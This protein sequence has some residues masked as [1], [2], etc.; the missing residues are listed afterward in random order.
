MLPL[1]TSTWDNKEV[2]SINEVIKSGQYTMNHLVK[3]FEIEYAKYNDSKYCV[4]V[5]SGSSANLLAISALFY[6]NSGLKLNPGDEVIVPAVSWSTT[7]A[8][9]I[10]FGLKIKVVDVDLDNLNIDLEKLKDAIT[11]KTKMIICVNLLGN[12]N[13]FSVIEEYI[14]NK[15]IIIFEDNCEA[16]GAIYKNKKT[17]SFGLVG[18]TSTFFSHIISTIEGGLIV[19]DDEELYQIMLS[20]RAHGWT[21]EL[22]DE[23]KLTEKHEDEFY[24]QF[25]FILPGF[26]LRPTEINGAIGLQQLKKI[27]NIIINRRKNAAFYKENIGKLDNIIIQEEIGESCWLGF[28]IIINETSVFKRSDLINS[29][30][31]NGIESRPIVAGNIVKNEFFQ[32]YANYEIFDVLDNSNKVHHNGFFIGNHGYDISLGLEKVKQIIANF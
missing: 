32:K 7:Y 29:L 13:D 19:T 23:N 4:M 12:A 26:N 21:R 16:M 6:K 30:K 1:A 8:P 3:K 24:E 9:L 2:D 11:D 27:D 20:M 18:T 31:E 14:Q 5:N 25:R 10:Q 22:P 15:D 28:S 17:G